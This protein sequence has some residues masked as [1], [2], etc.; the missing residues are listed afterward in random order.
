MTEEK[1]EENLTVGRFL[2]R[3]F[4]TRSDDLDLLQVMFL[5]SIAF[6]FVAFSFAGMG[7]WTVTSDAW[8]IFKWVFSI[9]AITG[10]PSTLAVLVART[11][12]TK[13][14]FKA[15]MITSAAERD[16]DAT[17]HQQLLLEDL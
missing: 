10:I 17:E 13:Y 4:F 1:E 5:A 6:F 16:E 3:L 8:E 15:D 9:L 12:T 14:K 7:T 2:Y 11:V